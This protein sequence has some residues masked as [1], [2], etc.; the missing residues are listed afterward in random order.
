MQHLLK[1]LEEILQLLKKGE[2]GLAREQFTNEILPHY[3]SI[4]A[5]EPEEK[6]INVRLFV[7]ELNDYLNS[8]TVATLGHLD[9]ND[10]ITSFLTLKTECETQA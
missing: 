2:D 9:L 10:V 8:D 1:T 7:Q 3:E 6:R 4:T 5:P